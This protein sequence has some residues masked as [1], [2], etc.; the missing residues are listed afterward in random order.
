LSRLR[1]ET[2]EVG[3]TFL[4]QL[5]T[6]RN[7]ACVTG[8]YAKVVV[9]SQVCR[10]IC[11]KKCLLGMDGIGFYVIVFF[12]MSEAKTKRSVVNYWCYFLDLFGLHLIFNHYVHLPRKYVQFSSR[13]INLNGIK[14]IQKQSL[15]KNYNNSNSD[16]FKY[17]FD[18][19]F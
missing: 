11:R 7:S 4:V 9:R 1:F 14:Q 13:V 15:K 3:E 12:F 18:H 2:K 19:Y 17:T 6:L 10:Y 8:F 5:S 16:F